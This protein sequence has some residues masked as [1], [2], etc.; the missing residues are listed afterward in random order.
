MI[1]VMENAS[2]LFT[3]NRGTCMKM[4]CTFQ[5]A[6][7]ISDYFH[8]TEVRVCLVHVKIKSLVKIEMM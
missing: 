4:K 6:G 7:K 5:E 8:P 1:L 2:S 3:D